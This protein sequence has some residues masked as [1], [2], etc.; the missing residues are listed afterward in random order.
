MKHRIVLVTGGFDPLH[1]GHVAYFTEAK[2][3]GS[4]LV[5]GLNSDSWLTRKKGKPFLTIDERKIILEALEIVD[6]VITF[7]DSDGSANLAIYKCLQQYPECKIIFANGGDRTNTT[8]PEYNTYGKTPWVEFKWGVGGTDKKNSSSVILDNWKTQ[9][10][11]RKWGYWRVLDDKGTIKTK[12]LVINPGCSLSDQRHFYRSEH[13]YVLTGNVQID[14][15]YN[16]NRQIQLLSPNTTY[17]I[18]PNVWHKTTNTGDIP[19]HIIEI[20]YGERCVEDDIER[21]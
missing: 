15:E 4:K 17:V 3:L 2:K 16:G 18:G 19:A 21:R 7:N 14:T 1:S 13:W 9:R 8:T 6:S 10:T 11:E 12:E 5:V 20:Q